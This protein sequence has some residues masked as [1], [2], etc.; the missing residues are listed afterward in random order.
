MVRHFDHG[1]SEIALGWLKAYTNGPLFSGNLDIYMAYPKFFYN[2]AGVV[3]YPLAMVSELDYKTIVITWRILNMIFAGL[4]SI[5]L[6]VLA[7]CIL[8]STL[9]AY[10]SALLLS[11]TPEFL[12]WSSNVRPN[13][14]EQLLIFLGLLGCLKIL[15]KPTTKWFIVST[16]LTALAFATKF[17]SIP[18]AL[19]IPLISIYCI[20]TKRTQKD[21]FT[22]LIKTYS[23]LFTIC[24]PIAVFLG[25]LI[26]ILLSVSL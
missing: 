26:T 2:L 13:P 1:E 10:I 19:L 20:W 15:G 4:A 23:T 6:F 24:L 16:I 9:A 12:I 22:K 17:G 5:A 8:Q 7:R 14:L 3:L 21:E 18:L 25:L 11:I